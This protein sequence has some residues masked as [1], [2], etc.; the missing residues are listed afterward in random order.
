MTVRIGDRELDRLMA[1]WMDEGPTIVA[2][3]VIDTALAQIPTTRRRGRRWRPQD[4]FTDRAPSMLRYAAILVSLVVL[5]A[6]TAALALVLSPDPA[7][8]P[9]G[10]T[11]PALASAT[12]SGPPSTATGRTRISITGAAE[13]EGE[14]QFFVADASAE[15]PDLNRYA[16]YQF[17]GSPCDCPAGAYL[18]LLLDP[19]EDYPVTVRT[20][21]RLVMRFGFPSSGGMRP[22]EYI[23]SHVSKS[24]ECEVVFTQFMD[25]VIEGAFTCF[26]VPSEVNELLIN[27]AGEFS[28]DP[29]EFVATPNE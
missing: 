15:F 7:P 24:G 13:M 12:P 1:A 5:I 11:E 3:T 19:D 28:F 22:D 4:V 2:E 16:F 18:H 9:P 25:T 14:W 10:P 21:D 23:N 8:Q 20:D 27:L 26:D 6:A 29:R 17:T